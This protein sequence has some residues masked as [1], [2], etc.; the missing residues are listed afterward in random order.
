MDIQQIQDRTV[1]VQNLKEGI[2]QEELYQIFI[3][4][5]LLE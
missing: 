2:T 4:F 5:G 3:S 1:F